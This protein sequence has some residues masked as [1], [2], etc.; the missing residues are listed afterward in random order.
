MAPALF[1]VLGADVGSTLLQY[2]ERPLA[3]FG[4]AAAALEL[5]AEMMWEVARVDWQNNVANSRNESATPPDAE[6]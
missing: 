6:D 2:Y 3:N 1:E 4:R 5:S